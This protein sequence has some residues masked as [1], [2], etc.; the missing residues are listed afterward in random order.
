MA[1]ITNKKNIE[2]KSFFMKTAQFRVKAWSV[3]PIILHL[4]LEITSYWPCSRLTKRVMLVSAALAVTV[5][6]GQ[7]WAT[8][9]AWGYLHRKEAPPPLCRGP[10]TIIERSQIYQ[11]EVISPILF[12]FIHQKSST[13]FESAKNM[14]F[15]FFSS[16]H[17]SRVFEGL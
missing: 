9:K 13:D 4:N 10:T 2:L 15:F 5:W 12:L 17:F 7:G 6:L 8:T 3:T 11:K 16:C 1:A 14:F